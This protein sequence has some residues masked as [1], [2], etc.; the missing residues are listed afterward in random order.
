MQL[1][2]TTTILFSLLSLAAAIPAPA[3]APVAAAAPEA[4]D[5]LG[6]KPE[7]EGPWPPDWKR[8][9]H[10]NSTERCPGCPYGGLD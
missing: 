10:D 8:D 2:L 3:P 5:G 7:P 6:P 1:K 4:P 9:G